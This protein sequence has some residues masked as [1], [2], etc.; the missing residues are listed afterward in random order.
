VR[1]RRVLEVSGDELS[2]LSDKWY[3]GTPDVKL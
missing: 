2:N 3:D 1:G